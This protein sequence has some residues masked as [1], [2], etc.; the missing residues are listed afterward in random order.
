VAKK[1]ILTTLTIAIFLFSLN[2]ALG[3]V[4]IGVKEGDWIE[5]EVSTS[6]N[7][8]YGHNV[9]WARMEIVTVKANEIIVNVTTRAMNGTFESGFLTLN[10]AKGQVGVWFI[11]PADLI[12]GE[13][14]FD[15]REN[16]NV[17]IEGSKQ[18]II[19]GAARTVTHATI[20]ERIKSWDKSTGVFVE[21]I[22]V[23]PDYTLNALAVKTNMWKPQLF[24]IEPT[25][26]YAIITGFIIIAVIIAVVVFIRITKR[27]S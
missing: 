20:P 11:I 18:R 16:R 1:L 12:P 8:P 25:I 3:E 17:T 24:G 13:A 5:Y 22:D 23:L 15:A 27:S 10:P 26:V 9:T 21:S 2:T 4:S 14:F 7:V 6:G 19:A